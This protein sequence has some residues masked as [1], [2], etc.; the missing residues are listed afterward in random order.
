MGN[1]KLLL[2]GVRLPRGWGEPSFGDNPLPHGVG[3]QPCTLGGAGHEGGGI[4]VL[5]PRSYLSMVSN[6][7]ALASTDRALL[8]YG[9][10]QLAIPSADPALRV[11][12][13]NK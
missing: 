7:L 6:Q 12:G 13:V 10:K 2:C 5:W 9:L 1:W 11:H 8:V 4:C 3:G